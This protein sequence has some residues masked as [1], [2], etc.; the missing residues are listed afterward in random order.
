MF[1]PDKLASFFD[2]TSMEGKLI[3]FVN[4]YSYSLIRNDVNITKNIDI[5]YSDGITTT[6]LFNLL[7]SKQLK[8]ISFDFSSVAGQVLEFANSK[9]LKVVFIGS[10]EESINVFANKLSENYSNIAFTFRNG[11]FSSE[12]EKDEVAQ[13]FALVNPDIIVVGMG[14]KLQE[15]FL[16]KVRNKGWSGT[17]YTCGGFIHQTANVNGLDYYPKFIDSLQLRW[18]YRMWDE[19]KLFKRY[20]LSYPLAAIQ[21]LKDALTKKYA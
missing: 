20:F 7:Y 9:G 4:P 18:L 21:I 14:A 5:W 12:N 10:T 17:G 16:I 6:V 13:S 8:R 15:E 11:Y 19:P 1:E 2:I 3:S